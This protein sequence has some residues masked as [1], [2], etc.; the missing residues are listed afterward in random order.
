MRTQEIGSETAK[1][2]LEDLFEANSWHIT[3]TGDFGVAIVSQQTWFKEAKVTSVQPFAAEA[4]SGSVGSLVDAAPCLP[5]WNIKTCHAALLAQ[6]ICPA[7]QVHNPMRWWREWQ[8]ITLVPSKGSPTPVFVIINLH[9]VSGAKHTDTLN[10][11]NHEMTEVLA[12][13]YVQLAAVTSQQTAEPGQVTVLAGDLNVKD[14]TGLVFAGSGGWHCAHLAGE[15]DWI[16][17]KLCGPQAL[18][19]PQTG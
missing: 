14:P 12:E 16:C 1:E 15:P 3:I 19:S 18:L 9:V 4:S 13:E 2:L 10:V 6:Q 7:R 5:E 17:V 11:R 8:E